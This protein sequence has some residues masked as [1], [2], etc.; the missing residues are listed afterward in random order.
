MD[1]M[2]IADCHTY[3]NNCGVLP[4]GVFLDPVQMEAPSLSRG[5]IC[6]SEDLES[7]QRQCLGKET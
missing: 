4:E 3:L 1:I 7:N 2:Y 5:S 6:E